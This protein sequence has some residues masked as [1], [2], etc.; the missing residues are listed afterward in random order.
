MAERKRGAHQRRLRLQL[1]V[2]QTVF[3]A[4]IK[5]LD[6]IAGTAEREDKVSDLS[7]RSMAILEQV[8]AEL[9]GSVGWHRELSALVQEIEAEL[10]AEESDGGR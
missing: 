1:R 9:D 3:R 4:E 6:L 5:R 8:R 7:S 2:V 10:R